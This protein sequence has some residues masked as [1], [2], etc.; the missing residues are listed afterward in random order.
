[1]NKTAKIIL[2]VI[3]VIVVLGGVFTLVVADQAV[4]GHGDVE[5]DYNCYT[6]PSFVSTSGYT[7]TPSQGNTYL[8]V[9][10]KVKNLGYESGVTTNDMIWQWH[11]IYNGLQYNTSIDTMSHPQY[12]GLIKIMPGY[13]SE[14]VW[15]FEV[16]ATIN[17]NNVQIT[18]EY[19][20][21]GP[22]KLIHNP[23][24]L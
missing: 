12:P 20:M 8:I 4:N 22:P 10:V 15:V 24:L 18:N 21:F 11:V 19:V 13:E 6:T 1:M 9:N 7:E 2:L 5:Y 3:A 14:F 17:L 16:P 23:D